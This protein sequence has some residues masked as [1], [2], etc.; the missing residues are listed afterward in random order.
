MATMA[1]TKLIV[2]ELPVEQLSMVT[3]MFAI[4]CGGVPSAVK[5]NKRLENISNY[6]TTFCKGHIKYQVYIPLF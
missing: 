3:K 1:F 6:F 4:L 5:T 2:N